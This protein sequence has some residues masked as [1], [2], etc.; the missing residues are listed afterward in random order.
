MNLISLTGIEK[1][2]IKTYLHRGFYHE[3][4][5]LFTKIIFIAWVVRLIRSTRHFKLL[6]QGKCGQLYYC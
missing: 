6:C 2:M 3:I 5:I 1:K 4:S